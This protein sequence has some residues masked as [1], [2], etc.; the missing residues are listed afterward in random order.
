MKHSLL[1]KRRYYYIVLLVVPL[2][3]LLILSGL[4]ITKSTTSA[5]YRTKLLEQMESA[6]SFDGFTNSLFCYEITADS[7]TTAYTL[8]NPAAYNIPSL[9]PTL[10]SFSYEQY[11]KNASNNT[12]QK[13]LTFLS[14]SLHHFSKNEL[15][16]GQQLTYTLLEKNMDLS[17]QSSGYPYYE[18]LLGSSTGVQA[19]LPVTLSE[20]PLHSEDDVITYLA[21]LKQI[22]GYF[23]DVI[24]YEQE[25]TRQDIIT[26][27]FLLQDTLNGT[28]SILEGLK[29]DN[30]CF[31]DTFEERLQSI[32][33]MSKKKKEK[34]LTENAALVQK[35]VI[36][37]YE[38]LYQYLQTTCKNEQATKLDAS[39]AYGLSSLPKGKNYYSLLVQSSTGSY[40]PVSELITMTNSA[41]SDALGEV[42]N[43]A[44][45]DQDAYLYYCEHPMESYYETPET[46]LEA[47]SLMIR[48]DYPALPDN[49]TYTVK[50]VSDSLASSLSPAFYMIPP[51]DDYEN[52]TIYINPLYTN[53]ENGNLFTTLAHE[54][55][56]GHLYQTVYF[57]SSNP[58]A[59]RQALNYPGYVEG[60]ATYV[61]MNAFTFIDYPLEGNSLCRLYQNDTIIN[62]ALCSRIDMGVNY[63]G[64]TLEDTRQFF[65]DNGF[66]SYYAEDIY[67]YV[68]EAPANYLSYFIGYLEIMNLKDACQRQDME[69]YSEKNFHKQFLDIGPADFDTVREY[70]LN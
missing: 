42:L 44:I 66:N 36:P 10:T 25:R 57:N 38:T 21:L 62:L 40:R 49:P 47:L 24:S 34:Y 17:L 33:H 61:E 20:Y 27:D 19:N 31:T 68:L 52:N 1:Y 15:D 6:K 3:V 2:L 45:T 32:E 26:P 11:K 14:N 48:E 39:K 58:T 70:L 5:S 12:D 23:Q 29:K 55:F 69:H 53:E 51:I 50:T 65:E 46:T 9:E 30:N 41:L 18:Y 35:Y 67:T 28:K 60:W 59:I 54:G 13:T 22:P 7:V 4:H 56:P 64:W 43:I 16:E 8:K 37:A 63:E